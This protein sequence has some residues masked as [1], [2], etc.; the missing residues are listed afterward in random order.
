MDLKRGLSAAALLAVVLAS[1]GGDLSSARPVPAGKQEKEPMTQNKFYCNA[2][3]L[4]PS[5]RAHHKL[6]TEKLIGQRTQI[7]ET[8]KG[9]EFQYRPSTISLAELADWVSAESKCC[10]FFGFHIDLENEGKLLCLRLIGEEGVKPF[11]RAEFQ[12]PAKL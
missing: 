8:E 10:P 4:N 9:Y 11:M 7:V 5:E 6:L 2:K 1:G 3:A 12:V